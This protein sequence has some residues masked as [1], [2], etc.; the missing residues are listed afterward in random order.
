MSGNISNS[1]VDK[2]INDTAKYV[3]DMMDGN[4]DTNATKGDLDEDNRVRHMNNVAKEIHA[5]DAFC[6]KHN[7]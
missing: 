1:R 2:D 6:H 3:G 7:Y 4:C 5:D